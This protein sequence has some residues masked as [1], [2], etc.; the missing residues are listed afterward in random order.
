MCEVGRT[1]VRLGVVDFTEFTFLD[2]KGFISQSPSIKK[3]K[4]IFEK[5]STS[6]KVLSAISFILISISI[7]Q[8]SKCYGALFQTKSDE[9]KIKDFGLIIMELYGMY[10]KQCKFLDC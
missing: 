3:N 8:L 6:I 2:E 10:W 5:V 4:K 7:Y 1:L 9:F